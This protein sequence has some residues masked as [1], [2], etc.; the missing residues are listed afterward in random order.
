VDNQRCGI[1][2][3][4]ECEDTDVDPTQV[5]RLGANAG[6]VVIYRAASG[7]DGGHVTIM[8]TY[9]LSS[10]ASPTQDLITSPANGLI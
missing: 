6:I 8:A 5:T 3:G 2:R 1:V 9:C 7:S 4:P 10:V